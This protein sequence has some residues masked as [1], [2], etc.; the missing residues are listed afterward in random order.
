MHCWYTTLD[1]AIGPP[2]FHSLTTSH[3]TSLKD[4]RS[5]P[6]F[7]VKWNFIP[8]NNATLKFSIIPQPLPLLV[9]I[10]Q[11][12]CILF[13]NLELSRK[14]LS[15]SPPVEFIL[16]MMDYLMPLLYFNTE[17]ITKT[18]TRVRPDFDDA[19]TRESLSLLTI[20]F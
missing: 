1:G 5:Y 20:A 10:S 19:S 6:F 16:N 13:K 7:Y 14:Y 8:L 4:I 15:T 12:C 11:S 18:N 9:I 17:A 2:S 3:L